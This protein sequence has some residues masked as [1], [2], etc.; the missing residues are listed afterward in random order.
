MDGRAGLVGLPSVDGLLPRRAALAIV[1]ERLL[2]LR[3]PL[4]H[5]VDVTARV[6][7][8]L[9]QAVEAL[10]PLREP[11]PRALQMLARR[12]VGLVVPAILRHPKA[13]LPLFANYK[14]LRVSASAGSRDPLWRSPDPAS[15]R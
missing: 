1:R 4:R 13:G 11:L 7:D 5:R 2:G 14:R 9:V 15:A 3:D 10:A 8:R 6:V 12:P